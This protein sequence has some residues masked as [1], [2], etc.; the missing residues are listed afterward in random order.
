MP[1]IAVLLLLA[2]ATSP[3]GAEWRLDNEH[4]TLSFV[5]FKK[6]HVGEVHTFKE[7]GGTVA[8]DGQLQIEI[9]L[10][11]VATHIPIR[12]KRMR[13]SL[14]ETQQFTTAKLTGQ[15]D[16]AVF[17]MLEEQPLVAMAVEAELA[18]H[19]EQVPLTLRI[20]VAR[21]SKEQIFVTSRLPVLVQAD[22]FNLVKGVEKLREL[23][24]LPSITR[25]VPV[26]FALM[27]NRVE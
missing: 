13:E 9:A 11:S 2:L 4:S 27:F 25:T 10:D 8:D 5:T 17:D 22:D 19:G 20:D 16:S 21:L 6:T 24:G 12:D 23:A 1:I 15:V 18:L 26:Q 7:L 14:F 3:V